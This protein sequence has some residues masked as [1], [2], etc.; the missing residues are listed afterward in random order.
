MS[1]TF[2]WGSPIR[3]NFI[4][5]SKSERVYYP[6]NLEEESIPISQPREDLSKKFESNMTFAVSFSYTNTKLEGLYKQRSLFIKERNK[7][8][9][10]HFLLIRFSLNKQIKFIDYQINL[11]ELEI[12]KI[13]NRELEDKK[14]RLENLI[15]DNENFINKFRKTV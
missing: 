6:Q 3:G 12:V 2:T 1:A 15:A 13:Q 4:S 11:I 8:S 9:R 14:I 10:S 7:L 5:N